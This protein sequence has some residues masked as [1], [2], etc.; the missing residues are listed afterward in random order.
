MYN[1]SDFSIEN[2]EAF[3]DCSE[4]QHK[5]AGHFEIGARKNDSITCTIRSYNWGSLLHCPSN[6]FYLNYSYFIYLMYVILCHL[7]VQPYLLSK[8]TRSID[9]S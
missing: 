6:Q 9:I 4:A 5:A 7:K 1:Y 2:Q 8:P 3:M